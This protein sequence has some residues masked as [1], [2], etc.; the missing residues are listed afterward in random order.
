MPIKIGGF[1]SK[2]SEIFI[3]Y[4]RSAFLKTA[5]LSGFTDENKN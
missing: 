2:S 5:Y 4:Q 3:S 1:F